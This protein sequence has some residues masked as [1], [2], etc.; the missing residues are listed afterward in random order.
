V[1]VLDR[2]LDQL[3]A[4][5]GRLRRECPWDREQTHQSL[6]PHLLEETYEVLDAL[7]QA[8]DALLREELG[9][10][11]VHVLMHAAIAESAGRF[12]IAEVAREAAEKM[13]RRHP[14]VFGD[15]EVGGSDEVVHNWEALKA[16][17]YRA[18]RPS[19]LD[20]VLRTLPALAWVAALQQRA[21]GVGFDWPTPDAWAAQVASEL[22]E[23]TA[24]A[25]AEHREA[26]FG[27]L[28][29]ALVA[30]GRHWKISA[31]NALRAAGGR[32]EA[33][34]RLLERLAS[35]RQILLERAGPDVLLRLW[36]E[37]SGGGSA[38]RG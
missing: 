16:Q 3:V 7:D 36:D 34:F 2:P 27:D 8:D 1:S 29:F 35:E 26:E 12:G 25:T 5:V 21:A 24:A 9:D 20:G 23:L 14:H 32:F 31:E 33:R 11:L 10:L 37:V 18:R 15:V 28:L 30:L 22:Q 19:A 17:E 13:V 38:G 6:R 4:V